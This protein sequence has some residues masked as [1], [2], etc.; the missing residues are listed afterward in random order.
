ME[1]SFR[2]LLSIAN[3]REQLGWTPKFADLREG[4]AEYISR[5]RDFLAEEER[6]KVLV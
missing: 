4:I 3:A 5:Y 6:R 1:A 2:G